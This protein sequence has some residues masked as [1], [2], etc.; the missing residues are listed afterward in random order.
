MRL[1][2][3]M[4]VEDKQVG[5]APAVVLNVS[6]RVDVIVAVLVTVSTSLEML[7]DIEIVENVEV[8]KTVRVG[9]GVHAAIAGPMDF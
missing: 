5:S 4:T 9:D 8:V 6:Q 1:V 2:L 7:V 3:V